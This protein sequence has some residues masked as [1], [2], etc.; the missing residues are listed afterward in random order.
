MNDMA[1]V[2]VFE[3]DLMKD[4]HGLGIT[5][6]GYVG[7]D[8][9]P[10]EISGIFVK[11]I[12]EGSAAAVD[13]RVHVNDQIIE[14]DGKSLR[15]FSNHQAV[16]VLRNTG[17]MVRLK[18][19]R[20]RHGP[21]YDK[22]QEYLAQA[23]Q[24]SV[25]Q[26]VAKES[27][28]VSN[29]TYD[30]DS[31][32]SDAPDDLHTVH[33]DFSGELSP[34]IEGTIKAAWEPIVGNDFL[35]VVAQ[36]AKFKEGGGLGISLEGTVDVEDGV[37]VRP[38]HYIRSI[39]PDGPV[40]LNGTLKSSDEL[41]E[42]NGR[43]LLGLNHVNVVEILKDLPQHVRLVC[44]RRKS[45]LPDSFTQPDMQIPGAS[46][47]PSP[48]VEPGPP[49]TERLVK[50]KSEMALPTSEST[51]H[52]SSLNKSKSRSLEPLTGLAMWSS[53]PVVIELEKGDKG[54]GFSILDYQDP[55]NPSETVIVIRSLVPGGVAQLDGRLVPGDRLVFV[56][57]VHVEHATLDEAV[58]A[59]KG[60][61]RGTVRIGVAKPLPLAGAFKQD[62]QF[63]PNYDN[64]S[65][66]P[67][68]DMG[69]QL[70]ATSPPLPPPPFHERQWQQDPRPHNAEE[71]AQV[72]EEDTLLSALKREAMESSQ[73]SGF[74]VEE[75][76]QEAS[77]FRGVSATPLTSMP[78]QEEL[79]LEI[80]SDDV[81]ASADRKSLT[82]DPSAVASLEHSFAHSEDSS[83]A[84]DGGGR[85]SGGARRKDSFYESDDEQKTP[86]KLTPRKGG[87]VP[88]VREDELPP[89]AY[90]S[91]VSPAVSAAVVTVTA[92]RM[93][94]QAVSPSP[95]PPSSSYSST[96]ASPRPPA[97]APASKELERDAA[98]FE[99]S[100]EISMTDSFGATSTPRDPAHPVSATPHLSSFKVVTNSAAPLLSYEEA[101]RGMTEPE[102]EAPAPPPR[103]ESVAVDRQAN[104]SHAPIAKPDSADSDSDQIMSRSPEAGA[105][106]PGRAKKTPP[107]IPPK[108]KQARS[109]LKIAQEQRHAR[110]GI[111]HRKHSSSSSP[112]PLTASDL[113]SPPGSP[114]PH[115]PGRSSLASPELGR[116]P[117]GLEKTI[118]VK[119]V[120][121]HL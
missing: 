49:L 37:E 27:T 60:A 79:H 119:K 9:T 62:S 24:T 116:L 1:D 52:Q 63:P 64:T 8:N 33:G 44:A 67:F 101:T 18:L 120:N 2:D 99:N 104:L 95:S 32:P 6:A 46:P 100:L 121:Q 109:L 43:R 58:Q 98:R 88:G 42:V 39:L 80:P 61:G 19:V 84:S 86:R 94:G 54:L 3:V 72:E 4:T 56:N 30:L 113:R 102:T 83:T 85:L 7:G 106:S 48:G 105:Q 28:A 36:L 91:A 112:D 35:V 69:A 55:V 103:E 21:K 93:L 22:L 57:D 111:M 26:V 53:E 92:E 34:E 65:A 82:S 87:G 40:G 5:I 89:P 20:F 74:R 68:T 10:D 107:P 110:S 71:Q 25:A 73:L 15:G 51:E 114:R 96:T 47:Y 78:A 11:S 76:A 41:L 66:S 13:G 97:P 14:V 59:L 38:H 118:H 90:E 12:T 108:P 31:R 50:A 23:N 16:E 77:T 75:M 29:P 70:T 45:P 115:S 81:A 17:Q 117:S